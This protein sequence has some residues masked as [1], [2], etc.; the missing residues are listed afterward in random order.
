[1]K[2]ENLKKDD[3]KLKFVLAD[4][5]FR[6][7]NAVRRSAIGYVPSMAI[8]N[9]TVY[10]NTSPLYEE[11]IVHRLG[12]VPLTTDLKTYNLRD[13]CKCNGKGCALCQLSLIL[14][15]SG[16]GVVY[17][18]DLKSRDPKIG[19]V[20]DKIPLVKIRGDQKIK[21]EM[22]AKLGFIKE[23]AKYQAGIASYKQ[24]S[25][26]DFEFFVES[27]NNMSAQEL[28]QVGLSNLVSKIDEM[29]KAFTD[30]TSKKKEAKATEKKPSEATEKKVSKPAAKK[31][32]SE[33]KDKKK[34]KK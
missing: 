1:M 15:K 5:N 20:Y 3:K 4:S 24:V 28:L 27:Y 33:A 11:M 25:E 23:H 10:E 14:E 6:L 12:L 8:E 17:S 21:M 32:D 19:P 34:A 16:P 9:V 22:T 18:G 30:A 26:N 31:K 2:I 29:K 7:A 13:E